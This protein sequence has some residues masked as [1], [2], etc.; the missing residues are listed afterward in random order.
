MILRLMCLLG[1][2]ILLSGAAAAAIPSPAPTCHLFGWKN[3][4]RFDSLPAMQPRGAQF[5]LDRVAAQAN[6]SERSRLMAERDVKRQATDTTAP[7]FLPLDAS[8][9]V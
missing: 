5:R 4:E 3:I 9:M 1:L 2:V 6:A 7:S 8:S